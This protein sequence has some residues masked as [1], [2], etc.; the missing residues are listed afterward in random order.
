LWVLK[1]NYRGVSGISP[2]NGKAFIELVKMYGNKKTGGG[3]LV[4][5]ID[6]KHMNGAC[7]PAT[8]RIMW[9]M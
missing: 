2:F 9:R 1:K 5:Q 8:V 7:S 6:G 4:R 3:G